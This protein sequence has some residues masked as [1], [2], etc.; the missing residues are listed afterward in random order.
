MLSSLM[1]N[2]SDILFD[3]KV[4]KYAAFVKIFFVE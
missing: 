1:K 2:P 3:G 4:K